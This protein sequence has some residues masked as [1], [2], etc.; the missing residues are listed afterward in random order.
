MF[1]IK[2]I[3]KAGR[4]LINTN[5]I[6]SLQAVLFSNW[7]KQNNKK[8]LQHTELTYEVYDYWF[9]NVFQAY[10]VEDFDL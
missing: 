9:E 1:K 5:N 2:P 6:P 4:K 7:L 8:G 10:L 3:Q